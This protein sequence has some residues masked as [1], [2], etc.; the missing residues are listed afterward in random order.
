MELLTDN[1]LY[2]DIPDGTYEVLPNRNENSLVEG[3]LMPGYFYNGGELTGTCYQHFAEGRY[4][5][6]DLLAP[7]VEGNV[8]IRTETDGTK[9][10]VMDFIDDAGYSISGSWR[11]P[12]K[13]MTEVP[14]GIATVETD[15]EADTQLYDL[16][17]RR[18]GR[19]TLQR[20]I[21]LVQTKDGIRKVLR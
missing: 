6:M 17:G 4:L 15:L 2:A 19:H 13:L 14:E 9:V 12:V 10:F 11:G 20:G 8:S 1:A 7:A 21:Q 3:A 5:V 18:M 16:Y